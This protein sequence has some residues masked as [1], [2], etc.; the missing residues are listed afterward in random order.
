MVI[1]MNKL[2]QKDFKKEISDIKKLNFLQRISMKKYLLSSLFYSVIMFGFNNRITDEVFKINDEFSKINDVEKKMFSFLVKHKE[3]IDYN[4]GI[5]IINMLD[6]VNE[7]TI[8][9]LYKQLDNIDEACEIKNKDRIVRDKKDFDFLTDSNYYKILVLALII[10][11]DD[12][13]EFLNFN[14][15]FWNDLYNKIHFLNLDKFPKQDSYGIKF[16]DDD[17]KIYLPKIVNLDTSITSINI[18]TEIYNKFYKGKI[19]SKKL[20]EEFKYDYLVKK[21]KR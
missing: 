11:I 14:E 4:E 9:Y 17:V 8:R 6:G 10:N 7:K 20:E 21:I 12:V 3:I 13:K 2:E 19:D 18:L 5:S 1:I 16:L 15:C